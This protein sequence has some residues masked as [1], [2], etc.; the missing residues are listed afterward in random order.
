MNYKSLIN[1]NLNTIGFFIDQDYNIIDQ[2]DSIPENFE[3]FQ[4]LSLH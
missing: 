1:D 2:T 3:F 4:I